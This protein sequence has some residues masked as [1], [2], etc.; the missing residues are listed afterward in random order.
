[1]KRQGENQLSTSE[2]SLGPIM[3]KLAQN[4]WLILDEILPAFLLHHYIRFPAIV[5]K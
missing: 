3:E 2:V 5:I 4:I 1:L